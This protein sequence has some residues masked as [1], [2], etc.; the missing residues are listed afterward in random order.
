MKKGRYSNLSLIA[1]I[2]GI[3]IVIAACS[4]VGTTNTTP[5]S[6]PPPVQKTTNPTVNTTPFAATA[7]QGG[8]ID[9]NDTHQGDNLTIIHA[10]ADRPVAKL[11][12][13]TLPVPPRAKGVVYIDNDSGIPQ[14]LVCDT[15]SGF[16]AFT[17]LPYTYSTLTFY[18]AGTFKAHLKDYPIGSDTTLTI[19]ITYASQ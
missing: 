2:L 19:I 16:A 17:I 8:P 14:T 15:S 4:P 7:D 11:S 3:L 13:T 1:F 12:Q 10:P 5:S 9:P 6:S 18:R